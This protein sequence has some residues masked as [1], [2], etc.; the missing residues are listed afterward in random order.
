ME[1]SDFEEQEYERHEKKL[2][3]LE[4]DVEEQPEEYQ[5]KM[6]FKTDESVVDLLEELK[7]MKSK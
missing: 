6:T 1:A 2:R 3:E 7:Q 4:S 5:G